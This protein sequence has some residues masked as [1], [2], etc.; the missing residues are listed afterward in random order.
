LRCL[1][2]PIAY[3][4][5]LAYGKVFLHRLNNV[6]FC[7]SYNYSSQC[8]I[9]IKYGLGEPAP[10]YSLVSQFD[11]S[12]P[13]VWADGTN[14]TSNPSPSDIIARITS[15]FTST[16]LAGVK[17]V[18]NFSDISSSCAQNFNALSSCFSGLGFT[19]IPS[20]H[21]AGA[22]P[23]NYTIFADAGLS[24]I[25]V[26]H[27]MSDFERRIFPLQ[28]AVDQVRLISF[29]VSYWSRMTIRVTGYHRTADWNSATNS[30]GVALHEHH[31]CRAEDQHSP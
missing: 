27:H 19:N 23:V 20:V 18:S 13:L 31:E 10:I 21:A 3:G 4:V 16:Q 25:D 5:F 9:F 2:L 11:G 15:N 22:P 6:C 12:K 7:P 26:E 14:G 24:H 1:I 29:C 17:R 8:L 30:L 28:W